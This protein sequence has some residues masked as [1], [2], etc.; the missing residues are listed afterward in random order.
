MI[1]GAL[2]VISFWLIL[3]VGLIALRLWA[4]R[5]ANDI[6]TPIDEVE[7]HRSIFRMSGEHA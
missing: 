4:S 7:V 2:I 1:L 3:D 6:D 5:Q